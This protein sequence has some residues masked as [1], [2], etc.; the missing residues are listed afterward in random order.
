MSV[1]TR[2]TTGR[3]RASK[4]PAPVP[5]PVR[6][7]QCIELREIQAL[8]DLTPFRRLA[9][10]RSGETIPCYALGSRWVDVE[11]NP[12]D[13]PAVEPRVQLP[14]E[15]RGRFLRTFDRDR[16]RT[17]M[18]RW[19]Y[20]FQASGPDSDEGV[21]LHE[22]R[23]EDDGCFRFVLPGSREAGTLKH[24]Y[25]ELEVGGHFY[26]YLAPFQL[27]QPAVDGLSRRLPQRAVYLQDDFYLDVNDGTCPDP[28]SARP[29]FLR[30]LEEDLPENGKV[31]CVLH[32]PCIVGEG[33]RRAQHLQYAMAELLE[34]YKEANGPTRLGLA[35]RINFVLGSK[36]QR[37][38]V[39]KELDKALESPNAQRMRGLERVI[40]ELCEDVLEWIGTRESV[41]S[42]RDYSS[43]T[44]VLVHEGAEEE[45]PKRWRPVGPVGTFS[46]GQL[47]LMPCNPFTLSVNDYAEADEKIVEAVAMIIAAVHH[48]LDALPA[49][50][51]WLSENFDRIDLGVIRPLGQAVQRAQDRT[52]LEDRPQVPDPRSSGHEALAPVDA[53]AKLLLEG[54]PTRKRLSE[55][56]GH[57]LKIYSYFFAAKFRDNALTTFQS[58]MRVRHRVRI[59]LTTPSLSKESALQA[60][61]DAQAYRRAVALNERRARLAQEAGSAGVNQSHR[62]WAQGELEDLPAVQLNPRWK[63]SAQLSKNVLDALGL[64]VNAADLYDKLRQFGEKK[65]DPGYYV[66]V[67]QSTTATL[68]SFKTVRSID[69]KGKLF[70]QVKSPAFNSLGFAKNVLSFFVELDRIAKTHDE[71]EISGREVA[72]L[73][74]AAA[75]A[76]TL[77]SG[78]TAI[79]VGVIG[80]LL[81][82]AGAFIADQFSDAGMFLRNCVFAESGLQTDRIKERAKTAWENAKHPTG[83][84]IALPGLYAAGDVGAVAWTA[85]G[86]GV[87]GAVA[88]VE[89]SFADIDQY[90]FTGSR[91]DF[92][93]SVELQHVALDRIEC[94]FQQ[95]TLV[96]TDGLDRLLAQF[97]IWNLLAMNPALTDWTVKGVVTVD[98]QR[99]GRGSS[100]YRV[101]VARQEVERP[102]QLFLLT[103]PQHLVFRTR[104]AI[105]LT[106]VPSPGSEAIITDVSFIG[107]LTARIRR[108][109]E[110]VVSK[111]IEAGKTLEHGNALAP[112]VKMLPI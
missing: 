91:A 42:I 86:V 16:S 65:N 36:D 50:R 27:P 79:V 76:A 53:G 54:K 69:W 22:L 88:K 94:A 33:V 11:G 31:S 39:A 74:Y 9:R 105:E 80:Y 109:R 12:V 23:Y 97:E 7:Y 75:A 55:G 95:P 51:E 46:R 29:L 1:P 67:L 107:T 30:E 20:V 13:A 63:D 35:Y 37:R 104:Y 106:R 62:A 44:D 3:R 68:E 61:G 77:L 6:F 14:M 71:G 10:S 59:D 21:L 47:E 4:T 93:A 108:P 18:D 34:L 83:G 90:W 52:T 89:R 19:V 41:R 84:R 60:Y 85:A 112:Y 70:K 58:F 38:F 26:F 96:L 40:E 102:V 98:E 28:G 64:A 15:G 5:S 25:L 73:G 72:M 8:H 92:R 48:D 110:V 57:V 82:E 99:R 78:G 45:A 103:S 49:G 32:L 87:D 56:T 43:W 100:L 111:K 81:Q 17:V 24:Q 66:G 2:P 101:T